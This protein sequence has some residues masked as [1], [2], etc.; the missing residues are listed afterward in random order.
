MWNKDT[1]SIEMRPKFKPTRSF[2]AHA[3]NIL[4]QRFWRRN[5][6]Y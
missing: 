1:V 6:H 2:F 5:G 4:R 3:I